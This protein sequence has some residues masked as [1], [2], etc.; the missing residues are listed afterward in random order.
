MIGAPQPAN[1]APPQFFAARVKARAQIDR[2]PRQ[3]DLL[4]AAPNKPVPIEAQL[5]LGRRLNV[6]A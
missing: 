3:L 4:G 1:P 6:L 2:L 5:G